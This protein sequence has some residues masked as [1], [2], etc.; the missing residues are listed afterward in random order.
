VAMMVRLICCISR[1]SDI[2]IEKFRDFWNSRE[3][4]ELFNIVAQAS[5]IKKYSH[6]LTLQIQI[7]KELMEYHNTKEPFDGIIELW[8]ENAQIFESLDSDKTSEIR[9]KLSEFEDQ[10]IDRSASRF[11][12]TEGE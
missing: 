5:Q 7:N 12:F 6:Q 11:F 2:S 4:K 8:W 3:Y 10:F 9:K 1:R